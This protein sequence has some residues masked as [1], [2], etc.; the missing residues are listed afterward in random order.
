MSGRMYAWPSS[1]QD[2]RRIERVQAIMQ[3]HQE[4]KQNQ[5]MKEVAEEAAFSDK[6]RERM[7]ALPKRVPLVEKADLNSVYFGLVDIL[8]GCCY[9][10][11]VNEGERCAESAWNVAKLSP[12]L[13]CCER[14]ASRGLRFG[15][16][17]L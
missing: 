2:K 11:R 15:Q 1:E 7:M 13:S 5:M 3:R 6:D 16:N 12:T 4:H 8:F 17:V 10:A 14:H 9:D